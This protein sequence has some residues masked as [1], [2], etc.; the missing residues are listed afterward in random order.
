ME[1]KP[2]IVRAPRRLDVLG[3]LYAHHF[4]NLLLE[5]SRAPRSLVGKCFVHK[6]FG[7][8]ISM[9]VIFQTLNNH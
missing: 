5:P 7:N 2:M 8:E 1:V 4:K 6:R 9:S 3:Q